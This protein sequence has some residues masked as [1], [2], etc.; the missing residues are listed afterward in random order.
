MAAEYQ[1][2]TE[3]VALAT[4]MILFSGVSLAFVVDYR[5]WLTRYVDRCT[6]WWAPSVFTSRTS[7]RVLFATGLVVGLTVLVVEV[8]A[9][10]TGRI[11]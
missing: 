3:A 7:Y 9:M 10:A 11:G 6:E 8:V 2:A 5:G 4:F 1:T